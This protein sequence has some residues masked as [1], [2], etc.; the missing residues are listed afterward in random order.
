MRGSTHAPAA[1]TPH[2]DGRA[3]PRTSSGIT[4]G[5]GGPRAA[6][7]IVTF[8]VLAATGVQIAVWVAIGVATAS[9]PW[10]LRTVLAGALVIGLLRLLDNPAHNS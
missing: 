9:M 1:E 7:R 4:D 8:A 6:R 5:L 10:W 2:A 3:S